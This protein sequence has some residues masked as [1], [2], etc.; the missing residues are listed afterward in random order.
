[1]DAKVAAAHHGG[2]STAV[3]LALGRQIVGASVGDSAAWRLGPSGIVDLTSG[4]HRRPMIGSGCAA[5]APVVGQVDSSPVLVASDGF[6]KYASRARVAA[7]RI[8]GNLAGAVSGLMDM[9]RLRSGALQDDVSVVLCQR[10][11]QP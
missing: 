1:V 3:V 9:V 5:I 7:I 10:E 2:E 4:Q 11:D 8:D 6:A